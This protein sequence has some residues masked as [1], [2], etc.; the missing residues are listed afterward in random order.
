MYHFGAKKISYGRIYYSTELICRRG[1]SLRHL[2]C[3]RKE[4]KQEK[5]SLEP[6]VSRNIGRTE[7]EIFYSA[8]RLVSEGAD[9]SPKVGWDSSH[10]TRKEEDNDY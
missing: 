5:G 1:C 6:G 3:K 10:K 8:N 4:D 9:N 2:L 7:T